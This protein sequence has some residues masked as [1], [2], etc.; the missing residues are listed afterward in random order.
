MPP[1]TAAASTDGTGM[2][3]RFTSDRSVAHFP[4]RRAT[5]AGGIN[6]QADSLVTGCVMAKL[7]SLAR[8]A[9]RVPAGVSGRA[10]SSFAAAF[11]TE[12]AKPCAM[13]TKEYRYMVKNFNPIPSRA[14]CFIS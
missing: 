10:G 7:S 3:I 5:G 14:K 12:G 4:R 2:G 13:K 9:V 11:V 6:S 8:S 1:V